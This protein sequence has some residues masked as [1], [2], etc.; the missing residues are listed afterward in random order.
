MRDISTLRLLGKK[1]LERNPLSSN[2]GTVPIVISVPKLINLYNIDH[3][4]YANLNDAAKQTNGK[5]AALDGIQTQGSWQLQGSSVGMGWNT[6]QH[7]AKANLNSSAMA[8]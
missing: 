2:L 3:L 6:I 4:M 1:T 7:M 8:R 5:R